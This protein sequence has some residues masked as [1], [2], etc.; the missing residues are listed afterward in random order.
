MFNLL[1]L[2]FF[3]GLFFKPAKTKPN[4]S[5]PPRSSYFESLEK[6]A[7]VDKAIHPYHSG[8]VRYQD[9]TWPARCQDNVTLEPEQI[10]EVVDM[11]NITLIVKPIFRP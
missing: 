2:F 9:T 3:L 6:E 10:C 8:R 7:I 1:G 11:H 4:N 5:Q